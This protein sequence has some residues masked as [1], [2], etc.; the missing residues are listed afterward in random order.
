M[1]YYII[2]FAINHVTQDED[3]LLGY[4]YRILQCCPWIYLQLGFDY[5]MICVYGTITNSI[6]NAIL[7][8][9]RG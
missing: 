3:M 4:V 9:L 1:N 7:A 5:S 6:G 2:V 8:D